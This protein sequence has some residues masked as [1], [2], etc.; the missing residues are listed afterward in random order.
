MLARLF[1]TRQIITPRQLIK[2]DTVTKQVT[3]FYTPAA[4]LDSGVNAFAFDAQGNLYASDYQ[5]RSV[6]RISADGKTATPV[7]IGIDIAFGVAFDR[8]GNLYISDA[9]KLLDPNIGPIV[10]KSG[11]IRKISPDGTDI[12]LSSGLDYPVWLTFDAQDTLYVSE[13]YGN[14]I[15]KIDTTTGA[16]TPFVTTGLD[17]PFAMVFDKDG[18]LFVSDRGS[19]SIKKILPDGTVTPFATTGFTWPLGLAFDPDGNLF[20][21]DGIAGGPI[22]NL[23][24]ISADGQTVTTILSAPALNNPR[25][26]I[27]APVLSSTTTAVPEPFTIVGTLIGGTAA[28]RL[29]KKL[30]EFDRKVPNISR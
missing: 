5:T 3:P 25:G 21:T 26:I 14:Q 2:I 17:R 20:A 6:N 29:R 22:S 28:L 16:E 12:V 8:Q 10:E 9:A 7:V 24:Q 4:G 19:K 1:S 23:N 18:N 13:G 27:F 30:G 15:K 11:K